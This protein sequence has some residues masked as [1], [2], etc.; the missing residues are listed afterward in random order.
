MQ[1]TIKTTAAYDR[2]FKKLKDSSGKIRI[3]A[4][5]DRIALGNFGDTK[6]IDNTI[7]ELRFFFGPGYRIYYLIEGDNI[8]LLLNGGDKKSQKDDVEQAKNI[9]KELQKELL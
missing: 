7:S 5:L 1:Y 6:P 8:I 9:L 3:L 2:W 4:R